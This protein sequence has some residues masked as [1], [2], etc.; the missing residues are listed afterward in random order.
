MLGLAEM[1]N[2]F[3]TQSKVY[4]NVINKSSALVLGKTSV[5]KAK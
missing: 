3:P 1:G 2:S 5:I 4:H